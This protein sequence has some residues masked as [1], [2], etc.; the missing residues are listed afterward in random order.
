MYD[1][2]DIYTRYPLL[3][4]ARTKPQG[5]TVYTLATELFAI[6]VGHTTVSFKTR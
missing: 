4:R 5:Y 6:L 1:A 2:L 3:C